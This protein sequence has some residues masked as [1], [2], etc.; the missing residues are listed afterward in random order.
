M[1]IMKYLEL[2]MNVKILRALR[3]AGTNRTLSEGAVLALVSVNPI[4][5]MAADLREERKSEVRS[6]KTKESID[7][8]KMS[9]SVTVRVY[10]RE[11]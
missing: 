3:I 4:D 7:T 8:S 6:I 5:L 2:M 10:G 11:D 9:V 1:K